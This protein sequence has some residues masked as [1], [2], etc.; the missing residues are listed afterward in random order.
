MS[1]DF[2]LLRIAEGR[3]PLE[4]AR[5]SLESASE[6]D[7]LNP[8]PPD[9]EK[10]RRKQALAAALRATSP[11]LE[12]FPFDYPEIAR[13]LKIP[14]A[15]ARERWRHIELN[16]PEPGSG[17]QIELFDDTAT[18]TVPYWHHGAEAEPV[19][20]EIWRYLSVLEREGGYRTYDPQLERV[21][22][23][24][25]DRAAVLDAYARGLEVTY[26]AARKLIEPKRAW[27][28]FWSLLALAALPAVPILFRAIG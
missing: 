13:Q 10:E 17:T 16:A 28:R 6:E 11:E 27:W 5:E 23:L 8:G 9:P 26:A 18:V 24:E 7:V 15:E 12:P 25:R 1:Y 3:D 22:D 4:Q 2:H 14:E 21:L 20:E 19:F